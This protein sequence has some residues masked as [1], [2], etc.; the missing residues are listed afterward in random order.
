MGWS[1]PKYLVILC[2]Y[3]KVLSLCFAYIRPEGCKVNP[4]GIGIHMTF[5]A[6]T[7]ET[8]WLI[9]QPWAVESGQ[10]FNTRGQQLH[11]IFIQSL[12]IYT[13]AVIHSF[14]QLTGYSSRV[15]IELPSSQR[16]LRTSQSIRGLFCKGFIQMYFIQN[17][18]STAMQ[19]ATLQTELKNDTSLY[20]VYFLGKAQA[21]Y[22]R[23]T[24]EI[25]EN[26]ECSQ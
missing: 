21:V 16:A 24:R 26:N 14:M 23:Q 18:V 11:F 2:I 3:L 5:V 4:T 7:K 10:A 19:I 25:P 15:E 17:N 6:S 8:I 9:R 13:L 20:L 12:H 1:N 22:T